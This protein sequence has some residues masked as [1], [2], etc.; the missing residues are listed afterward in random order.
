MGGFFMGKRKIIVIKIGSSV[1]TTHRGKLDEFR[2]DHFADQIIGLQNK[3]VWVI[4]VI[5]GAVAFGA[6]FINVSNKISSHRRAAAGIGQAYLISTLLRIFGQKKLKIA[7]ILLSYDELKVEALKN[8]L[9]ETV[10]IYLQNG[11]IPVFNENDVIELNSF[12]GNDYLAL[13]ITKLITADKLIILSTME[14]S[15][16]GVGGGKSKYEVLSIL[17]NKNIL[18]QIADGRKRNILEESCI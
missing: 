8:N 13:E 6:N 15:T 2:L 1:L 3:G 10:D 14:G 5:S 7:Q 16:F 9:R 11:I 4:F 12:G 17:K 18:A